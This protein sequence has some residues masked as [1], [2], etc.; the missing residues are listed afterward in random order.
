[1]AL[2]GAPLLNGSERLAAP[3]S[4]GPKRVRFL[5]S[6]QAAEAGEPSPE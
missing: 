1:M 2:G 3:V 4:R 5:M 6:G